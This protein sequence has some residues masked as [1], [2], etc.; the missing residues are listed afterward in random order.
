MSDSAVPPIRVVSADVVGDI[1]RQYDVESFYTRMPLSFL[2]D[3]CFDAFRNDALAP[4][5]ITGHFDP[6][7]PTRRYPGKL[8]VTPI[9]EHAELAAKAGFHVLLVESTIGVD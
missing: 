6:P 4:I 1:L 9:P 8:V 7:S 3:W 2:D 5:D